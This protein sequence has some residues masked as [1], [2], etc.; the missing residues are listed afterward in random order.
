MAAPLPAGFPSLIG[1]ERELDDLIRLLK[2]TG[3]VVTLRGPG[4][5][6]K[7]ALA[8]QAAQTLQAGFTGGSVVVELAALNDPAQVLPAVAAALQLPLHGRPALD[9]LATRFRAHPTL[10]V[11]DNFEQVRLASL[12]V[13]RLLEAAPPLRVLITSRV[14]RSVS[15]AGI[16]TRSSGSPAQGKD[17]G[18]IRR[19]SS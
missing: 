13:Q 6:G 12:D 11:L 5:I 2:H 18:P 4:G 1:R 9:V 15:G 16:S 3:H 19:S 8:L 7:T 17:L 14:P 10:L